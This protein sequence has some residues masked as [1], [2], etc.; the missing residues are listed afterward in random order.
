MRGVFVVI[1]ALCLAWPAAADP[2]AKDLEGCPTLDACLAI[3]DKA[4]EP[5]D[6]G[7]W[8][9]DTEKIAANLKRFGEAAKQALLSRATG[10]HP[11]WRNLASA[12]LSSWG[13]W[14]EADIPKLKEVLRLKHGGWIARALGEIGSPAAIEALVE[15][16]K[17]GSSNQTGYALE[18]LGVKVLP[19]L[20]PVL[21][22]EDE[23]W[24]EAAAVV[25][26]IG[27]A[28]AVIAPDWATLA[29]NSKEPAARRIGALRGL[30]AIGVAA[31]SV[32]PRI[33][34]LLLDGPI[35]RDTALETLHKMKDPIVLPSLAYGCVPRVPPLAGAWQRSDP[36]V[37]DIAAFGVDARRYGPLFVAFL[38][39]ENGGAQTSAINA[40]WMSQYE[41]GYALI[42]RKLD[43]PDWRVVNE[44]VFAL[45][46]VGFAAAL[47]KIRSIAQNHWLPELRALAARVAAALASPK[48]RYES[49]ES[50]RPEWHFVDGAP[51]GPR[52][53]ESAKCRTGRWIWNGT[54]FGPPANADRGRHTLNIGP[55]A[56]KGVNFGEWGGGLY[57]EVGGTVAQIVHEANVSAI[58]PVGADQAIVLFGLAHLSLADGYAALGT[59]DETGTWHL[60]EVARMPISANGMRKLGPD[61]FAA[62]SWGRVVIFSTKG[63]HGLARCS[64]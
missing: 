56:L 8:Y 16:L 55:G 49:D 46:R 1:T 24:R 39:S 52:F 3:L 20:L 36:C 45:G 26:A 51:H 37:N 40:I 64:G 53:E 5:E 11:G 41:P 63:I 50:R 34:N 60:K 25:M 2:N 33:R 47:P 23:T 6:S 29:T 12:I 28:A 30:A 61:L 10:T 14:N 43:S 21:G 62:W 54:T 59:R 17:H 44:A 4:V 31:R 13:D 48:G 42:E 27:E 22:A 32:A 9:P 57:W 15:D 38:D 7:V 18:K 35:F 19:Y 58:E